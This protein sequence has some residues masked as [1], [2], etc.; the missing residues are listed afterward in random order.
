MTTEG[1]I[2]GDQLAGEFDAFLQG[3]AI[4]VQIED[5]DIAFPSET[6]RAHLFSV[7]PRKH[8]KVFSEGRGKKRAQS[9]VF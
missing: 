6:R 3:V 7:R 4:R 5:D 2:R 1:N 8:L 9:A